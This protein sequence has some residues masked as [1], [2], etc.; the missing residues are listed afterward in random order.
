MVEISQVAQKLE[1]WIWK[2]SLRRS[3]GHGAH[4]MAL[5][6]SAT[7]MLVKSTEAR[8]LEVADSSRFG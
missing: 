4:A 3:G 5:E 7:N 8:V 2:R 1:S 6:A